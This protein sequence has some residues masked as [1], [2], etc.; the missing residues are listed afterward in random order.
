MRVHRVSIYCY[1]LFL[2]TE[3]GSS[4]VN[5]NHVEMSEDIFSAELWLIIIDH[6][7]CKMS[8][9]DR[10]TNIFLWNMLSVFSWQIFAHLNWQYCDNVNYHRLIWQKKEKEMCSSSKYYLR[11]GLSFSFDHRAKNKRTLY[12]CNSNQWNQPFETL[13]QYRIRFLLHSLSDPNRIV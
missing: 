5:D 9:K 10:S 3:V 11:S 13:N 4:N 2:L 6:S 7:T 8:I 12:W 1:S